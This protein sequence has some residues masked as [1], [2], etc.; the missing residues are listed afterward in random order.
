MSRKSIDR[1]SSSVSLSITHGCIHDGT[2]HLATRNFRPLKV[3]RS[4]S[5]SAEGVGAMC[6]LIG[7]EFPWERND[8]HWNFRICTPTCIFPIL[9]SASSFSSIS[10]RNLALSLQEKKI[11]RNNSLQGY[12]DGND[13]TSISNQHCSLT[14]KPCCFWIS[15]HKSS[16]ATINPTP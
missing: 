15:Y 12:W 9:L 2:S 5:A 13:N 3:V 16:E 14:K 6:E 11:E 1:R 10:C 4:Y 8:R 7:G